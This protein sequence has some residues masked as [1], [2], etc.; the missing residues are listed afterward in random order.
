MQPGCPAAAPPSIVVDQSIRRGLV[1]VTLRTGAALTQL[2]RQGWERRPA[3]GTQRRSQCIQRGVGESS[4]LWMR[5]TAYRLLSQERSQQTRR[6]GLEPFALSR[7]GRAAGGTG[8]EAERESAAPPFIAAGGLRETAG[9]LTDGSRPQIRHRVQ[10][11]ASCSTSGLGQEQR[12]ATIRWRS[13]AILQLSPSSSDSSTRVLLTGP[14]I[15]GAPRFSIGKMGFLYA[16]PIGGFLNL[17]IASSTL[18]L[19][20]LPGA[21]YCV[22]MSRSAPLERNRF[23][24]ESAPLM[25]VKPRGL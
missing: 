1:P 14:I 25:L 2:G 6:G 7:G 3:G 24:D 17:R 16:E 8:A 23:D 11:S 20:A 12:L 5:S 4:P 13:G 21:G 10:S 22:A 9:S 18:P 19:L 15:T